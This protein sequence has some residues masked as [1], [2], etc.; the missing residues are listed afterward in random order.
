MSSI[1]KALK[2]LEEEKTSGRSGNADIAR[3]ILLGTPRRTGKAG[4]VLPVSVA[5]AAFAA[6]LLTYLL[7]VGAP[8]RNR[9]VPHVVSTETAPEAN[10]GAE[11]LE[12]S[13]PT[14]SPRDSYRE[15]G[16]ATVNAPKS[17]VNRGER[18]PGTTPASGHR[19]SSSGTKSP[20]EAPI[21][22]EKPSREHAVSTPPTY[23]A[24]TVQPPQVR[25]LPTLKVSGI[26][27]QKDGA[28]RLAVINGLPVTEGMTVE[29][30]RVEEIFQDKV[31]FSFERRT[32]D[33]AVGRDSQ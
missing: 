12:T 27:W 6:A 33:V 10:D 30:A 16:P 31:R 25:S 11:N 4:W 14:S 3:A 20:D 28:N 2:K 18:I 15:D 23:T 24:Q 17:P 13:A 1:L 26:A 5:G 32:F 22:A 7:T 8:S 19:P 21:V 9:E 29:G